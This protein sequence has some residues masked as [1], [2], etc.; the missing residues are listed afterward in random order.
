MQWFGFLQ[1]I[2]THID[3]YM[4]DRVACL[5]DL[6]VLK[7]TLLK[8]QESIL[9]LF[10][11]CQLTQSC[12]FLKNCIFK[13]LCRKGIVSIIKITLRHIYSPKDTIDSFCWAIISCLNWNVKTP[14]DFDIFLFFTKRSSFF[15]FSTEQ[16]NKIGI[17]RN[18]KLSIYFKVL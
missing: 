9:P 18:I 1:Q 6:T 14:Y 15:I 17:K 13:I 2:Y 5:S 11:A 4:L 8:F 3:F 10:F 7:I 12:L 16:A